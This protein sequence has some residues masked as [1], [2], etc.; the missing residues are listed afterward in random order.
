[1][2]REMLVNISEGEESRIAVVQDGK[3]DE[4]Y[5]ERYSNVN[6]VGNI[7]K[8][9]VVNVEP[10]IQAAFI[11]FGICKNGFLHISDVHPRYFGNK[12]EEEHIGRRK[13]INQ[14]PP[15]QK[16]LKK[17][18]EILV[19]VTKEGINTKGPTLTTYISLPG[20]YAVMMPWM[21]K[22]GISQKIE[23]EE[24]RKVMRETFEGLKLPEH[25]GYIVRTAAQTA[26]KRDLQSDVS[27]LSRLWNVILKRFETEKGLG[28]VY[29]E[30]DLVIRTVR[31]MFDSRV[32][33]IMCDSEAMTR[34]IKDFIHIVQPRLKRRVSYYDGK[35]PLFNKHNLEREIEKVQSSRVDLKIGGSIV[36]E[37]T[38][39]L[40]AI[41]VNS[42]K[43]RKQDNAEQTALK[44]N[45]EAAE[46]IVRQLKLRDL[47]GLIVCDFIDM[48]EAKNKRAVEKVFRDA[49]R[50]DRARSKVLRM[51]QFCLIELTRQRMRPSLHS[52]TY[53]TCPHCKGHG[54][55]KSYESQAIEVLRLLQN[56][57]SKKNIQRIEL[58]V[59]PDVADYLQNQK[60]SVIWAM[61]EQNSKRITIKSD[62]GSAG[63]AY[64]LVCY[65]ERG[66]VVRL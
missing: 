27:Y 57:A 1:M 23:V 44:I 3:L 37:Q 43:Y 31:D 47:G 35:M 19:Q 65:D 5:I 46:E 14:R 13:S 56:A 58:T 53:L 33:R 20:K 2:S 51:S 45:L 16:C 49:M 8:G 61:E 59:C 21:M 9:R 52:S 15:I 25:C 66:S 54:V 24:E 30:S 60:R 7:Y 26:T 12:K 22:V 48:R 50:E 11:D 10:S 6:H 64:N 18:T 62:A 42:G 55:I 36:I 38:E 41:D 63:Q 4:L 34:Q 39:A 32:N 17:G 29:Q 40:V 28:E